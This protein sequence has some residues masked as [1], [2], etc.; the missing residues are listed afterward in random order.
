MAAAPVHD[1]A[2]ISHASASF[3]AA[4][5]SRGLTS[6]DCPSSRSEMWSAATTSRAVAAMPQ[7][8]A[9]ASALPDAIQST[10]DVLMDAS[11]DTSD[12]F[13]DDGAGD[14][15]VGDAGDGADDDAGGVSET[16]GSRG[17]GDDVKR[18]CT[19]ALS[20]GPNGTGPRIA[21]F[22]TSTKY[23]SCFASL[24]TSARCT[25]TMNARKPPYA[26]TFA[27]HATS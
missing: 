19:A 1:S 14:D 27:Q 24:A 16:G 17:V 13:V 9:R 7:P 15:G 22:A 3:A 18:A 26:P 8:A 6:P 20:S 12:A 10:V 23:R 25:M 4:A 2:T 11:A 21:P 5:R